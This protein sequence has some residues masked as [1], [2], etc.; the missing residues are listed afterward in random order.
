MKE[1]RILLLISILLA[2]AL[3][4]CLDGGDEEEEDEGDEHGGE[5][6]IYRQR[7]RDFVIS[8]GEHARETDPGFILIPQNGHDILSLDPGEAGTPATDYIAAIDGL[9]QEDLLYGYD[10]KATPEDVTEAL[11][12]L[13]DLG[14]SNGVEALVTDYC[15][16][17]SKMD[18]S[19]QRNQEKD[20]ISFAAD[21]RDLDNIPDH[22]EEPHNVNSNDIDDLSEAENFL[23]LLDPSAFDSR[24]DYLDA[25]GA[26]DH[27]VL[28][29]DAFYGDNDMLTKT[30]VDALKVKNNG[31]KRLV[32]SYMSIGE[33]EDYRDYWNEEWKVGDPS[34]LKEENPE[35]EGNYKVEYWD[36][37]WQEVIFGEDD[38]YADRLLASG[39]DGAYL[40]IIEAFEYF[41]DQD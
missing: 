22:P 33:A 34:F 37:D 31:G 2:V 26:T 24:E 3:S 35:W 40:D 4:G 1:L 36:P 18:D 7:M 12:A 10:D 21:H 25:L 38:S 13:L 41:E 8:I 27:D 11:Q 32:I 16:T 19:Y 39:F 28:I 14:E 9:G 5:D 23:Y 15:W 20:Y 17:Q 29:I 30:E 6:T